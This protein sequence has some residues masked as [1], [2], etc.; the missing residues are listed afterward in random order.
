V[1]TATK[2]GETKIQETPIAMTAF[3][4]ESFKLVA[5]E[6]M[7][8]LFSVI[9]NVSSIAEDASEN[10]EMFIR[11]IGGKEGSNRAAYYIDGAYMDF[12][13]GSNVPFLGIERIEL[14]RGPQGTLYGRNAIAGVV[15]IV[16]KPPSDE[17]EFNAGIQY[18]SFSK[19]KIDAGLSFPIV[20]NKVYASVNAMHHTQDGYIKNATPGF[21][22]LFDVDASGV[23]ATIR[24]T[25]NENWDIRLNGDY[26][27][28]KTRGRADKPVNALIPNIAFYGAS[29][30]ED[31]W[32]ISTD[33]QGTAKSEYYG[34][35]LTA[36]VDLTDTMTLTSIS[37][38]RQ[39][40]SESQNTDIDGTDAPFGTIHDSY[41]EYPT[42]QEE[43]RLN[44]SA[45]DRLTGLIGLFY[46]KKDSAAEID[47]TYD[48][49]P[50]F[51]Y[52]W[53]FG[54]AYFPQLCQYD[55]YT[56]ESTQEAYAIFGQISYEITDRWSATAGLRYSEEDYDQFLDALFPG[57]AVYGPDNYHGEWDK[58]TPKIGLDFQM[59]EEIMLYAT[60]AEGFKAGQ[61]DISTKN[62]IDPE[63]LWSYEVGARTDWF[64]N[65]LRANASAFYYVFTDMQVITQEPGQAGSLKNA[66]KALIKG[67]ELDLI[68]RPLPALTLSANIGYL[69]AE[70]DDFTGA[71]D[72]ES[73]TGYGDASGNRMPFSPEWTANFSAVYVFTLGEFG[74]LTLSGNVSYTDDIQFG[75]FERAAYRQDAYTLLTAFARFDTQDNRWSLSVS[76]RN[77]SEEKYYSHMGL[78]GNGG[79]SGRPGSPRTAYAELRYKF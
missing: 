52:P 70:F 76:G 31:H 71:E 35:S 79:Y 36:E 72:P 67:L 68:A 37:S 40:I 49:S 42:Y 54:P 8:E 10:P 21:D 53:G 32:T 73:P 64:N 66:G 14:L 26:Y 28:N 22:D 44:F 29:F 48:V 63:I 33:V 61:L 13:L 25:P 20:E 6:Q 77:L 30:Y 5:S 34:F 43:L 74:F 17:F 46:F 7:S 69:D 56:N 59:T 18:G 41:L 15:N 62:V 45:F 78:A 9:P 47:G 3:D 19:F 50:L 27:T 75:E 38:Y 23:R 1:V 12:G 58:I 24:F 11:G 55:I 51:G 4:T 57:G 39:T 2:T 65:R 60:V 16:T